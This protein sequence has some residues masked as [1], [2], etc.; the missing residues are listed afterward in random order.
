VIG[1]AGIHAVTGGIALAFGLWVAFPAVLL[2]G[3]ITQEGV[4]WKLGAI[5]G[6]DWLA[7]LL[8]IAVIVTL[9]T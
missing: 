3:S 7:K 9:W 8:I 4:P 1:L 5:H 6:G 2:I